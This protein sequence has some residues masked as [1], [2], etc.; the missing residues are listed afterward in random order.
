M[1]HKRIERVVNTLR[2]DETLRDA[3]LNEPHRAL[4]DLLECDA[5][6]PHSEITAL[7]ALDPTFWEQVAEGVTPCFAS[8]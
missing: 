1:R 4:L 2:A 6:L 3:F 8:C 7:T 5:H